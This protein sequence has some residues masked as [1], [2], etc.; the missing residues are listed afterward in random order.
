MRLTFA[1]CNANPNW[2]P[3]NPKHMFQICQ[4]DNCGLLAID[5]PVRASKSD[6][7]VQRGMS[8]VVMQRRKFGGVSGVG[9]DVN[10]FTPAITTPV[11]HGRQQAA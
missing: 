5:S 11:T 10:V 6:R 7:S 4:N 3:R 1:F 9:A 2:M 8:R